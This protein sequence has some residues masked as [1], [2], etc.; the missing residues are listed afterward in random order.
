MMQVFPCLNDDEAAKTD[1]SMKSFAAIHEERKNTLLSRSRVMRASFM[2]D[3]LDFETFFSAIIWKAN[4]KFKYAN[5]LK[6]HTAESTKYG[7][8][9]N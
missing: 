5:L 2:V 3:R 7:T 8:N 4:E 6:F 9:K 1:G